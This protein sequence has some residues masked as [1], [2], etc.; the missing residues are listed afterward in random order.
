MNCLHPQLI[1]SAEI[2]DINTV[3]EMIQIIYFRYDKSYF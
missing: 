2:Y 1:V 3:S